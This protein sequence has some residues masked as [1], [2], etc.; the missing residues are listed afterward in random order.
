MEQT[1]YIPFLNVL[2]EIENQFCIDYR[3]QLARL[4]DFVPVI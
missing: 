2:L 3:L 1:C 4:P